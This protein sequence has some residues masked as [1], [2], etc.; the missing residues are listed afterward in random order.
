MCIKEDKRVQILIFGFQK[1]DKM[2]IFTTL[3]VSL[4][5]L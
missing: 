2:L 5:D 1:S 4:F 3:K